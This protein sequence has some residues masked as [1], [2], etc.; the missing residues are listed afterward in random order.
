MCTSPAPI[1]SCV[2]R[3]SRRC[4]HADCRHH[5][6][7][8]V[9]VGRERDNYPLEYLFCGWTPSLE[10]LDGIVT[11]A[12]KLDYIV[13]AATFRLFIWKL[14]NA[15]NSSIYRQETWY[16]S[17]G[18]ALGTSRYWCCYNH[19]TCSAVH[20]VRRSDRGC[21]FVSAASP[22]PVV[23]LVAGRTSMRSATG[24]ATI[25]APALPC[26]PPRM[27]FLFLLQSHLPLT[28]CA[29]QGWSRERTCER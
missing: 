18:G 25:T 29:T 8:F 15:V 3:V 24:A 22:L 6:N 9:I 13:D 7:Q 26:T 12:D 1:S 27:Q 20:S 14:H 10:K 2:A 21:L 17:H 16:R 23:N 5:L 4:I 11:P 28:C 19:R